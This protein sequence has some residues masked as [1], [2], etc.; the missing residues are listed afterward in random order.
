[1]TSRRDNAGILAAYVRGD[2]IDAIRARYGCGQGY[3]VYLAKLAGVPVRTS[4]DTAARAKA[5]PA[6]GPSRVNP[7]AVSI[8]ATVRADVPITLPSLRWMDAR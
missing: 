2:S 8:S 5:R 1:M 6:E 7:V 4:A 3:P